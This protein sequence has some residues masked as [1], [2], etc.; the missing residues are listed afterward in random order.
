MP[1]RTLDDAASSMDR[2]VFGNR[3]KRTELI[4]CRMLY[5]AQHRARSLGAIVLA[6]LVSLNMC[7]GAASPPE[8]TGEDQDI[9]QQTAE[10][11]DLYRKGTWDWS[12]EFLYTFDVVANPFHC[13]IDLRARDTNP[14]PYHFAT[15]T[16]GLRYRLTGVGGPW[17]LRGSAQLCTDLVTTAIVMGPESYFV[18]GA[19]GVH[20]DF[21]QPRW[22]IVPYTDFRIGPG[23]IDATK[24]NRGQQNDLE[25]TYLWGAGLRYNFSSSLSVSIGAI[26]QHLSDAWLT[27]R[28]LSVDSLG[29]NIRVERKF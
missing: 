26:D 25:F 10:S 19:V 23:A 29:V 1:Y 15:E 12:F 18:G 17:F 22:P 2:L 21:I 7:C 24:G 14:H 28:N 3:K 6:A 16:I 20:Y 13:L 5:C 9:A 27:P 8:A 4:Y 11:N